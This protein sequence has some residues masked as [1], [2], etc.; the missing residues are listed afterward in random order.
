MRLKISPGDQNFIAGRQLATSKAGCYR[1]LKR[2]E[3]LIKNWNVEAICQQVS[4]FLPCWYFL[5][6]SETNLPVNYNTSTT[7]TIN[8][9]WTFPSRHVVFS[10]NM[11]SM[12][13]TLRT[14]T[15]NVAQLWPGMSDMVAMFRGSYRKKIGFW[16]DQCSHGQTAFCSY[17]LG[18]VALHVYVQ[19]VICGKNKTSLVQVRLLSG[20]GSGSS[21]IFE[22]KKTSITCIL[23]SCLNFYLKKREGEFLATTISPLATKNLYLIVIWHSY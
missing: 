21:A 4:Y 1:G 11:V 3:K 20:I 13:C 7:A 10:W 2:S 23:Y 5:I 9:N 17:V 22:Q 19:K 16:Y 14:G 15:S 12:L 18:Q 8:T 6:T